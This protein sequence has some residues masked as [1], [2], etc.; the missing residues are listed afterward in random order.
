M[1]TNYI[2]LNEVPAPEASPTVQQM[3]QRANPAPFKKIIRLSLLRDGRAKALTRAL[4]LL[5]KLSL[6]QFL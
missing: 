4:P 3:R 2:R 6:E 1:N 5:L